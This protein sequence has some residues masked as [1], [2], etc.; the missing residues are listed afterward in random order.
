MDP[1]GGD[2]SGIDGRADLREVCQLQA[3]DRIRRVKPSADDLVHRFLIHHLLDSSSPSLSAPPLHMCLPLFLSEIQADRRSRVLQASPKGGHASDPYAWFIG[4]N[5]RGIFGGGEHLRGQRN[6]GAVPTWKRQHHQFLRD[7]RSCAADGFV[8][9]NLPRIS[10]KTI[11]SW[12]NLHHFSWLKCS[13]S[14][15][16]CLNP[17]SKAKTTRQ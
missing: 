2:G 6:G 11:F 15:S 13:S 4:V 16:V 12:I 10:S 8:L 3:I 14:V 5:D 7:Y 1:A 9:A 17:K